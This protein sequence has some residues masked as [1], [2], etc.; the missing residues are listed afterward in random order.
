VATTT[1]WA[2]STSVTPPTPAPSGRRLRAVLRGIGELFI[3][4]GLVILLFVVYLL[5]W[6][7]VQQRHAQH[8][9]QNQLEQEWA[10]GQSPGVNVP[11]VPGDALALLFIPR[12]GASY[13][14]VVVKDAYNLDS[15]AK[16]PA[17][18][19]DTAPFGGEGNLAIAGHRVTHGHPFKQLM[20]LHPDD[21]IV[22]ETKD[23]WYTYRAVSMEQVD[24]SDV[25][26]ARD[27]PPPSPAGVFDHKAWP[28]VTFHAGQHLLTFSTCTPEYTATYRL[29]LHGEL[30]AADKRVEG[31][32]PL[33]LRPGHGLAEDHD[34]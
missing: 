16:G 21:E 7:D 12:L 22:F 10:A 18:Y 15:L 30:V 23:Y 11:A 28:A 19:P 24:P 29:I 3:T 32:L 20:D 25:A 13:K 4:C 8:A 9:L 6:T 5:W 31:F 26:V 27:V 1:G 14:Q 2:S 34:T 17:T 33:A